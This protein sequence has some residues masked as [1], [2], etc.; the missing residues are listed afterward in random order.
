[1]IDQ[2]GPAAGGKFSARLE[3]SNFQ[4]VQQV[5]TFEPAG[6]VIPYFNDHR[7]ALEL[8]F[9]KFRLIDRRTNEVAWEKDLTRTNFQSFI[10]QGQPFN[11]ARF[12]YQTVG[13]AILLNL[14]QVVFALDPINQQ[15]LWEKNLAGAGGVQNGSATYIDPKDGSLQVLYPD[16][17]VQ[18]LGQVG[19][20]EPSY[21]CLQTH[22]GLVALDPLTGRTLWTRGDVS[23]R[24]RLFGDDQYVYLVDVTAQGQATATRALRASDGAWVRDVPDFTEAFQQRHRVLGGRI[25][26]SDTANGKLTLRLYDI[27][28]GKD[29]WKGE[30]PA[31]STVLHTEDPD[32]G[33]VVDPDGKVTVIDL[34]T[35]KEVLRATLDPKP[36]EKTQGVSLL[37]DRSHYYVAVNGP[38][39]PNLPWAQQSNFMPGSGLRCLPVNGNVFA[40]HRD[41]GKLHYRLDDVPMEM[42]V[43]DQF[44]DLPILLFTSRY[45]KWQNVGFG[46]N[47]MNGASIHAYDKRTGKIFYRVDDQQLGQQFHSFNADLREGKFELVSYNYKVLITH[48]PDGATAEAAAKEGAAPVA[49]GAAKP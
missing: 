49:P 14:G 20:V 6:E 31:G 5:F 25:L 32:L 3:Q 48:T 44:Q 43:L 29:V 1:Y 28:A 22:D 17:W 33:G 8:N 47:L 11:T 9:H 19:A 23:P 37:S 24:A 27:A 30:F 4:Q 36:P 40:F 2:P 15:L 18:H 10:Y 46:R 41:T 21:V 16:G 12:P 7:V 34:R 26:A 38:R 13:H 35:Q 45:Q 42:L 39:D